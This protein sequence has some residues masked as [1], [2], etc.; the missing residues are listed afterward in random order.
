TRDGID[1]HIVKDAVPRLD[2]LL[3]LWRVNLDLA[4]QA[5][6]ARDRA[7]AFA[8]L[9]ENSLGLLQ[10][11][12]DLLL[13][14]ISSAL[15]SCEHLTI[16]PYGM[17][18]YLPFHCLFDGVQFVIERLDVSYL[19]AAALMEI[20][21]QRGQRAEAN[22]IPLK[23]SLIMG[24]SDGGRLA[25]AVQEAKAVAQQLGASCILDQDATTTLLQEAGTNSPIVHI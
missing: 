11:L 13:K 21:H 5:S 4:A 7:H 19:P 18:H 8:G 12:Y 9:Q 2:R 20:C 25:F 14:P 17:L 1:V 24:L 10:L 15:E 6:G 22:R 16:V 3:S 23:K